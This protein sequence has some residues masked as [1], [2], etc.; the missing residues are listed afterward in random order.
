VSNGLVQTN[1]VKRSAALRLGLAVIAQRWDGPIDLLE[2]GCSAG[3]HLRFDR[4]RYE[5]AGE[6]YGDRDSRVRIASEWRGDAILPDLDRIPTIV[7]RLGVDLNP[8]DPADPDQPPMI[9]GDAIDLCQR[10]GRRFC[11]LGRWWSFTRPR[12][13]TSRSHDGQPSTPP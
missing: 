13:S 9:A 1:E 10:I 8:I 6:V 11:P 12:D 7:N 2:I 5:L 3:I 4:Y